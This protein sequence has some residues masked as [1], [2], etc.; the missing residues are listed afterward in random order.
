MI[1]RSFL[2]KSNLIYSL[3]VVLAGCFLLCLSTTTSLADDKVTT[4]VKMDNAKVGGEIVECELN[5]NHKKQIAQNAYKALSAMTKDYQEFNTTY[6]TLYKNDGKD[7]HCHYLYGSISKSIDEI[8]TTQPSFGANDINGAE[9][10]DKKYFKPVN[11][12]TLTK[13]V[14]NLNSYD[15][16][17]VN[18]T[19]LKERAL[20]A[21]NQL[22]KAIQELKAG[23]QIDLKSNLQDLLKSVYDQNFDCNSL[24]IVEGNQVRC[25]RGLIAY[26]TNLGTLQQFTQKVEKSNQYAKCSAGLINLSKIRSKYTEDRRN[27]H[28][29]LAALSEEAQKQCFCDKDSGSLDSCKVVDD[30]FEEDNVNESECKALNEYAAE[31][32]ICLMVLLTN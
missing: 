19:K 23:N 31:M 22:K 28:T 27:A 2:K 14:E 25:Y 10:A 4:T 32:N 6:Q 5:E 3:S 12:Y 15:Y 11:G 13:I 7:A 18:V 17:D 29:F 26:N 30:K 1:G 24:E 21:Q 9:I 20:H 8:F 16:T